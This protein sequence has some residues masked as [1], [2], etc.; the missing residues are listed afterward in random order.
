MI[1][2]LARSPLD[3]LRNKK[4]AFSARENE[5]PILG[6]SVVENVTVQ[7]FPVT[8]FGYYMGGTFY[9]TVRLILYNVF[10]YQ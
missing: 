8:V 2:P 5:L 10:L 3:L 6:P 1:L 7:N 4:C 9:P